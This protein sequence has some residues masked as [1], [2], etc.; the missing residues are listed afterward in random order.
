MS[1]HIKKASAIDGSDV[2]YGENDRWTN[3]FPK[4]KVIP[5]YVQAEQI[6]SEKVVSTHS[7]DSKAYTP[8]WLRKAIIVNEH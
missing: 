6:L 8:A 5:T 3:Y 7:P 2:Y 1:Y 4:R